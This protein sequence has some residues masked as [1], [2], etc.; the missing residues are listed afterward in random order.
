ME[1]KKGQIYFWYKLSNNRSANIRF[2]SLKI[3]PAGLKFAFLGFLFNFESSKA[4]E[5]SQS[6]KCGFQAVF[7][8]NHKD[9][10]DIIAR[11]IRNLM[12]L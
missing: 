6:D 10:F 9:K 5:E 1:G 12:V 7:F 2:S 4:C 8:C 3:I 11:I